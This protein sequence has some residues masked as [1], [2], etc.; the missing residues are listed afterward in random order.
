M[1][2]ITLLTFKTQ[3]CTYLSQQRPDM[4][5]QMW[6]EWSQKDCLN[7]NKPKHK[8]SVHPF[9]GQFT[10]FIF[11][12]LYKISNGLSLSSSSLKQRQNIQFLGF[13][14]LSL[15]LFKNSIISYY[16]SFTLFLKLYSI[17]T[18]FYPENIMSLY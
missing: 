2:T 6:T 15:I 1:H 14:A 13:N 3:R 18:I 12:S 16:K 10:V 7:F 5:T 4:L 17:K 8:L 11:R 9:C